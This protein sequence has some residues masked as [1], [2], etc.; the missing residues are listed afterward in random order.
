[1]MSAIITR[2]IL[3][4]QPINAAVA[5]TVVAIVAATFVTDIVFTVLLLIIEPIYERY[6]NELRIRIITYVYD[7]HAK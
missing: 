1:M 5:A 6:G 4:H 3:L 2:K 7:I